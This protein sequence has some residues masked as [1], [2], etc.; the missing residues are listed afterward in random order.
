M[1]TINQLM[2]KY[3]GIGGSVFERNTKN[4]RK[5]GDQ[6]IGIGLNIRRRDAIKKFHENFNIPDKKMSEQI[7]TVAEDR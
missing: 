4:Q 2:E 1:E 5:D 6:T 3:Y 7:S